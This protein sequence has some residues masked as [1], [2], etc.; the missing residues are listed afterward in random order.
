MTW[1][2]RTKKVQRISARSCDKKV[3]SQNKVSAMLVTSSNCDK[4][5]DL[6]E[7]EQIWCKVYA[8]TSSCDKK[9]RCENKF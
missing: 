4:K 6:R 2:K 5:Y 7:K 3:Q 8:S 1:E 9:V